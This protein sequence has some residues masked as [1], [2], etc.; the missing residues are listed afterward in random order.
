MNSVLGRMLNFQIW[1][2]FLKVLNYN[3][4]YFN[5]W[6]FPKTS[7]LDNSSISHARRHMQSKI[8]MCRHNTILCNHVYQSLSCLRPAWK[9]HISTGWIVKY[10]VQVQHGG[11]GEDARWGPRALPP[12]LPMGQDLLWWVLP[13]QL[14]GLHHPQ[15]GRGPAGGPPRAPPV[16][17]TGSGRARPVAV[18]QNR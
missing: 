14:R 3:P 15:R 9:L 16:L 6:I 4:W 1:A 2:H 7:I 10:L 8:H 13:P 18:G 12:A 17:I 11:Q 5:Q